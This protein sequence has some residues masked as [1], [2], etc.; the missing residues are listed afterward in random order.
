M[1]NKV[2]LLIITCIALCVVGCGPRQLTRG[3][4]NV[5]LSGTAPK[6]CQFLGS[7]SDSNVHGDMDIRSSVQDLKRDDIV[8][9]KNEG[10]KLGANVVVLM[11]HKSVE[12]P[13]RYIKGSSKMVTIYE[14]AI[15]ANAYWCPPKILRKLKQ[16]G[17]TNLKIEESPLTKQ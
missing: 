14:H 9:L 7:I 6:S 8:F 11:M 4:E 5:N 2:I 12:L 17:L 16:G 15:E 10:A 3:A 13:P 1:N